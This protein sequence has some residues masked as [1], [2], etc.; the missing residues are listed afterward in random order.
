[1]KHRPRATVGSPNQTEIW[2]QVGSA[3]SQWERLQVH[4]THLFLT[5]CECEGNYAL[6]RAFGISV[7]VN[8]KLEMIQAAAEIALGKGKLL[9]KT[10]KALNTI[11]GLNLRRND[12]AHKS[13]FGG[14]NNTV[15]FMPTHTTTGKNKPILVEHE[16]GA[17]GPRVAATRD[18]LEYCWNHEDIK[19]YSEAFQETAI[20]LNQLNGEIFSKLH[21]SSQ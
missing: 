9:D 5:L 6:F 19:A 12:I 20:K 13:T 18:S 11:R 1:M 16:F 15:F 8:P 14:P 7:A 10:T 3:L 2:Q 4:L 21:K 17:K